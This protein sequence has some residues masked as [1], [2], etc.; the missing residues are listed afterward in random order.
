M[1]FHANTPSH[2]KQVVDIKRKDVQLYHRFFTFKK[3]RFEPLKANIAK[4][5][6]AIQPIATTFGNQ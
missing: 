5:L 1:G 6:Y 4:Y 3:A 2:M